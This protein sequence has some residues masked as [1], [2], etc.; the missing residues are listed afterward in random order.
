MDIRPA[1]PDDL[2]ECQAI[3]AHHVL[4]GTGTFEEAPPSLEIMTGRYRA[5]VDAGRSWLVAADPTGVLG[6]AYF[7]QYRPRSAYRF[8]AEDSVYVRE[9]VRGQGVGKALVQR[10]LADAG[11]AGFRQMLAVIGD[12]QNIGSIGVHA[13][14]GF[15]RVGILRDVGFKFGRWLDVVIMQRPLAGN[16]G[17]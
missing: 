15:Q 11:A 7:D 12:S 9:D 16:A 1:T 17:V 2:A 8:A 3:Y 13:S 6:F 10:L 14:L 5:V 4:E